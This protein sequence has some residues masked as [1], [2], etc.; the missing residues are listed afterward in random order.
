MC[1]IAG[2][3]GHCISTHGTIVEHTIVDP[4]LWRTRTSCLACGPCDLAVN[5][6]ACIAADVAGRPIAA[7][8]NARA[9]HHPTAALQCRNSAGIK[10]GVFDRRVRNITVA[11]AP[12]ATNAWSVAFD[13][14][15]SYFH[16]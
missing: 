14:L 15:L 6:D 10:K 5:I 16:T 9:I 3:P 1:Q 11:V 7:A 12:N 4:Y 2:L 8:S 13:I